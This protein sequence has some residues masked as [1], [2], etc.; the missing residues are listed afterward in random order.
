M[1]C[2]TESHIAGSAYRNDTTQQLRGT[3]RCS[4]LLAQSKTPTKYSSQMNAILSRK[5]PI[6]PQAQRTLHSPYDALLPP[7]A[8]LSFF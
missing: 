6:A 3:V 1:A 8:S 5:F 7:S 2:T 4:P